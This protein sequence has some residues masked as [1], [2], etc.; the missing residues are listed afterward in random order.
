MKAIELL[1][2]GGLAA[3]SA[4]DLAARL[5]RHVVVPCRV[6][7]APAWEATVLPGREQLDA[8]A[9]LGDLEARASREA[10]LVGLTDRD[11]AIPI[12]TFVFGR[13]RLG[14]GAALVSLARLDPVFYGLPPDPAHTARRAEVEVRHELGH[15][16][17][18][19]HCPDGSCLMSFAGNVERVDARGPLFCR[20]CREALPAWLR[21]PS[22][23]S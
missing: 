11:I 17:G 10:V 6:A 22:E 7:A 21:P 18:L 20:S 14:G 3:A 12:F 13:A 15:L 5:S 1:P 2:L 4:Q 23:M 9:L 8:D 16:A 19:A